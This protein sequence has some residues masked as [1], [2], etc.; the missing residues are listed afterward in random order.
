MLLA[1]VFLIN[2]EFDPNLLNY[3]ISVARS[4]VPFQECHVSK[5]ILRKRNVS[6]SLVTASDWS[7]IKH[8]IRVL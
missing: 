2:P 8:L 7:K 1:A 5:V 3:R 4:C 6:V